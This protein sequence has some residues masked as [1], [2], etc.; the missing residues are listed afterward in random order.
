MRRICHLFSSRIIIRRRLWKRKRLLECFSSTSTQSS[1][2]TL[3][4]KWSSAQF[5]LASRFVAI[6][7]TMVIAVSV[8]PVGPVGPDF[9]GPLPNY[10]L[11]WIPVQ[12]QYAPRNLIHL[13]L[14]QHSA[15]LR[16]STR[17]PP[18]HY[19]IPPSLAMHDFHAQGLSRCLQKR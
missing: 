17:I 9:P 2:V 7:C 8:G 18:Y 13:F 12:G 11:H 5:F 6:T 15:S 1:Y 19:E 4:S 16:W 14:D 3:P 10:V